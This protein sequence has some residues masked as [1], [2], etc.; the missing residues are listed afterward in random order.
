VK[1]KPLVLLGILIVY[2]LLDLSLVAP[3]VILRLPAP[4]GFVKDSGVID[5]Q[6]LPSNVQQFL[7]TDRPNLFMIEDVRSRST[8]AVLTD[9]R[10]SNPEFALV[11]PY[12]V[13]RVDWRDL[14]FSRQFSRLVVAER[15]FTSKTKECPPLLTPLWPVAIRS[16]VEHYAACA[17]GMA[18]EGQGVML[19]GTLTYYGG[20]FVL[21]LLVWYI[22]RKMNLWMI[23][24]AALFY[25]ARPVMTLPVIDA[26][27]LSPDFLTSVSAIGLFG[28]G[29]VTLYVFWLESKRGSL[30]SSRPGSS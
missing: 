26:V 22:T 2:A 29:L 17:V 25:L 20:P 15:V 24:L 16:G 3:Q 9:E 18:S 28:L 7:Q 5:I 1:I 19:V 10:V 23:L 13:W 14:A 30:L 27:G 8:Y 4:M 12:A 11:R 21:L 6:T